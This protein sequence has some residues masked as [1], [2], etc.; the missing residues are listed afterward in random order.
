MTKNKI[1][2][3]TLVKKG[4]KYDVLDVLN[5]QDFEELTLINTLVKDYQIQIQDILDS[6]NRKL[7]IKE[8][9]EEESDN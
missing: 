8:N 6:E 3:L 5:T 7:L 1:F 9:D 2:E 4:E